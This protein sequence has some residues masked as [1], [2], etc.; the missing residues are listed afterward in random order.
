[1]QSNKSMTLRAFSGVIIVLV[2]RPGLS[3]KMVP[4]VVVF[5]A[6]VVTYLCFTQHLPNYYWIASQACCD[7]DGMQCQIRGKDPELYKSVWSGWEKRTVFNRCRPARGSL[8]LAKH[9]IATV[10]STEDAVRPPASF[11][12]P[13]FNKFTIIY[14]F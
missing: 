4:F 12:W 8:N 10:G 2:V 1:M 14:W 6:I 11:R 9:A 3:T 13:S 7:L 5:E